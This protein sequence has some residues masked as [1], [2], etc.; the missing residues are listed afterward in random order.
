MLDWA[1]FT[2]NTTAIAAPHHATGIDALSRSSPSPTGGRLGMTRTLG[3]FRT[4]NQVRYHSI[5]QQT[6]FY[7]RQKA[8]VSAHMRVS[9]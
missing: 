4:S 1:E 7:R 6:V 5:A 3:D 8:C 9:A 2:L